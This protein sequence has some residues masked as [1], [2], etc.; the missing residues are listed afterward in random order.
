MFTAL[1]VFGLQCLLLMSIEVL[2]KNLKLHSQN[3]EDRLDFKG[4]SVE[5]HEIFFLLVS[6]Q[7]LDVREENAY[8]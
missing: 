8:R 6:H 2:F 4:L 5:R 3:S 7:S 1:W